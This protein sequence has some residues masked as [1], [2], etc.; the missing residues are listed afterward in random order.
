MNMKENRKIEMT[1]NRQTRGGK[2][3]KVVEKHDLTGLL[4]W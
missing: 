2:G 3:L 4:S 1:R